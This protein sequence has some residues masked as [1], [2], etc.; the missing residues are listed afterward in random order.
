MESYAPQKM[1]SF[2]CPFFY[3]KIDKYYEYN[4]KALNQEM[5][6]N[7]KSCILTQLI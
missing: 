7:T 5:D 2:G 4:D 6:F 3:E 1:D